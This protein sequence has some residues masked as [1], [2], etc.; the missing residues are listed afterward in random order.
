MEVG[1]QM[2]FTKLWLDQH[3]PTPSSPRAQIAA[4]LIRTPGQLLKA[5]DGEGFTRDRDLLDYRNFR[6]G[7]H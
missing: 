1:F 5:G 3:L 6:L 7:D 2:A 4:L